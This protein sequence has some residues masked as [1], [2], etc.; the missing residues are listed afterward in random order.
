M[1][2]TLER[3]T[4]TT[5]AAAPTSTGEVKVRPLTGHDRCDAR[6]V[7]KHQGVN[8][9]GSCGAQAFVLAVLPNGHEL[10]F[11]GHHTGA[12]KTSNVKDATNLDVL[13]SLGAVIHSQYDT[14]NTK[15][16]M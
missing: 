11:C 6:S 9:V 8:G 3:P 14:I 1:P 13:R 12:Q 15:P 5:D 4:E 7:N 10:T 2:K 16:T